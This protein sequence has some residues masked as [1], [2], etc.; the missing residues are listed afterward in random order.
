NT[1][2]MIAPFPLAKPT[3][4][5]QNAD[6]SVNNNSQIVKTVKCLEFGNL[7]DL[8][9]PVAAATTYLNKYGRAGARK[10]IILMTDGAA[11]F[12]TGTPCNSANVAAN[13]AKAS[14]IQVLTIGF[15]SNNPGKCTSDPSGPFAGSTV[16]RLLASMA[17]PIKG[18]A[19]VD[20][21]SGC[22]NNIENTDGDN[23]FCQPKG[24]DIKKVFLAAVAQLA[25]RLPR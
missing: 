12:P 16:T 25:N 19:A 17:S 18:V 14:G 4:D 7:T 10:G 23:F 6:G 8:G 22:T 3:N 9:D 20:N 21:S 13:G 5:Y 2:W 1:T 15:L 24:G 11:N